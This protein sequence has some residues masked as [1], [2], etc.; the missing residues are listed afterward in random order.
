MPVSTLIIIFAP[1]KPNL[2]EPLHSFRLQLTRMVEFSLDAH[3]LRKLKVLLVSK[4]DLH[5]PMG[6]F[7][8]DKSFQ[9][10][11]KCC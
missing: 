11:S 3:P 2:I 6:F 5:V 8:L 7:E 1:P 9:I 4:R 10:S